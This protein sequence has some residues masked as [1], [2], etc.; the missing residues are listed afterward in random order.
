MRAIRHWSEEQ[1]MLIE[2]AIDQAVACVM[3]Q[4][5]ALIDTLEPE[6]QILIRDYFSG[7]TVAQLSKKNG[8][9]ENEI[10]GWLARIRRQLAQSLRISHQTKQ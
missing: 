1:D 10:E 4:F 2:D 5:E 6:C 8:L 7:T 9:S 3:E